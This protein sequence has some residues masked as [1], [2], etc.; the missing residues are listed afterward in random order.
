M[1][2]SMFSAYIKKY[3]PGVVLGVIEKLNDTKRP[4]T[5]L[6][7]RLLNKEYSISGTWSAIS[8]NYTLVMADYVAYDSSIPLKKRDIIQTASGEIPKAGLELQL[9]EK[10][11]K[12]LQDLAK[13]IGNANGANAEK[14][15]I[16]RFVAKL[17]AD[18][19]KVIGGV[20]ERNE[21]VFLQGLSTGVMLVQDPGNV[22]T[23][24]RVD[25][26]F[27][28][29]F[30]VE[31]LYSDPVNAKP[32][33]DFRRVVLQSQ[34]DGNLITRAF[35]DSATID[36]ICKTDQAKELYAFSQNFVGSQIPALDLDKLNAITLSRHGFVFEK[37]DRAVR[38]ERNGTQTV[39]KPW[40][41]GAISFLATEKVGDLV[42]SKLA[43]MEAPVSG[44]D[45]TTVDEFILVSKFRI[46]RPSLKE[47]T[48]SQ[49][50]VLP[51]IANTDQIYL[52]D[53]TQVEA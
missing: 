9:N 11:L 27:P 1:E 10:Q 32:F 50:L 26:N 42:W 8:S 3:L 38:S 24:L 29:K 41:A 13:E 40:A 22:G 45:Y 36:A 14:A 39:T 16:K 52:M 4:L 37:V 35:T 31:V 18:V 46:N 28:N 15:A 53:T 48:N 49:A 20:Y 19:A 43:E 21:Q 33:D 5:Y 25:F 23:G 34:L 47:V 7:K 51:V 6:H 30:G 44:V 17:F 12:E 2:Q